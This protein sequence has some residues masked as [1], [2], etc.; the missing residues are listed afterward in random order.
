[1]LNAIVEVPSTLKLGIIIPVYKTGG[2]HP[3]KTDSHHGVI[4]ISENAGNISAGSNEGQH[5]AH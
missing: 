5:T 2:R 3:V 1:M 4:C